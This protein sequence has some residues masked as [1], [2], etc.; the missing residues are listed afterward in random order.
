MSSWHPHNDLSRGE[1][2]SEGEQEAKN[3]KMVNT[4]AVDK[5]RSDLATRK[6][7]KR[8]RTHCSI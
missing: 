1:K 5:K 8:A 4:L 3:I 7:G 2:R 6:D